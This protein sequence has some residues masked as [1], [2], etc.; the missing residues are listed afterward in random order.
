MYFPILI[1]GVIMGNH[2]V[3]MC[4]GVVKATHSHTLAT[5]LPCIINTRLHKGCRGKVSMD[6]LVLRIISSYT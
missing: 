2:G 6:I 5:P 4:L 1:Y 3:A